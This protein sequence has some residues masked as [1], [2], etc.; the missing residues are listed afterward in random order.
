MVREKVPSPRQPNTIDGGYVYDIYYM[1]SPQ[2]DFRNLENIL[3][4]EALREDLIV[5][6]QG[7]RDS[8][9]EYGD[10]EDSNDESNWRNDYPDEDEDI[11]VD[12]VCGYDDEEHHQVED[13]SGKLHSGLDKS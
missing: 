7:R 4:I 6:E 5:E 11:F 1:N 3:A 13:R 12:A 2:F 9:D 8:E 10:D